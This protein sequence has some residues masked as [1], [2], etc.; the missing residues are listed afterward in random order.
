M[1]TPWTSMAKSTL[2]RCKTTKGNSVYFPS[3]LMHIFQWSNLDISV[4][5]VLPSGIL[6]WTKSAGCADTNMSR[7]SLF[8][9]FQ[10]WVLNTP[11][12][13]FY[14]SQEKKI[15][16]QFGHDF[17]EMVIRRD[18]VWPPLSITNVTAV[19]LLP[20]EGNSLGERP[21]QPPKGWAEGWV[22]PLAPSTSLCVY[23]T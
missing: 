2:S 20:Q 15:V 22:K 5:G 12:S 7:S 19:G 17:L 1:V 23:L 9:A 8:P 16:C 11:I 14:F 13:G 3:T 10:M 6:C 21:L 4:G 18:R